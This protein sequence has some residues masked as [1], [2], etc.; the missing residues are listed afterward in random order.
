MPCDGHL[1]RAG[2]PVRVEGAGPVEH[3]F[4][5]DSR[6]CGSVR[7]VRIGRFEAIHRY[8]RDLVRRRHGDR[9]GDVETADVVALE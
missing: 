3:Q 5:G 6:P 9:I 7:L 4:G 8:P 2:Q 1:L